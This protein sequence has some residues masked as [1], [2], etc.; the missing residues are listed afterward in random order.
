M[1]QRAK[2]FVM[3][4]TFFLGAVPVWGTT[5][6]IG[7]ELVVRM[8]QQV[9]PEQK[10]AKKFS[11]SLVFPVFVDGQEALPVGSRI[12][13]DVRGSKKTIFLVPRHLLLP[14][15]RRVDFNA[16][17]REIG[18]K[19]LQAERQEGAIEKKGDTGEAVQQ[20]GQMGVTGA[21]IGVMTTGT[22]KGTAIGAA[23]GVGAVLIGRQIWGRGR[24]TVIPA[25]T[26]LTL[27]LSGTFK[28]PD[29]ITAAGES[30]I[31]QEQL[32]RQDRRPV[33]RRQDP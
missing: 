33:L 8:D 14:D 13:G 32:S 28:V 24:S 23:A 3:A 25:G 20:A 26:Q 22:A 6:P 4:W 7:T 19:Q 9:D 1:S 16:T 11:A 30:S 10:D 21:G 15:G 5:L 17:V 27:S 18:S 31:S 29:D 12:E 2:R